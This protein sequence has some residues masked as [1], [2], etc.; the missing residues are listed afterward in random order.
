MNIFTKQRLT[1]IL[2]RTG[3]IL[4]TIACLFA[5]LQLIS[6]A[7]YSFAGDTPVY[8]AILLITVFILCIVLIWRE[9]I[10]GAI[11][12]MVISG[13]LSLYFGEIGYRF[14]MWLILGTPLALAGILLFIAGLLPK[15]KQTAIDLTDG[16]LN[17]IS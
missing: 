16:G 9:E 3:Q 4:G 7:I 2:K 13:G 12:L 6:A 5:I 10:P 15:E 11:L 1:K 8:I 17:R 14:Y